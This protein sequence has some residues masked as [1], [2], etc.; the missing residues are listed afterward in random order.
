[1]QHFINLE[2]NKLLTNEFQEGRVV[3]FP[4]SSLSQVLF[5]ASNDERHFAAA[6]WE[7]ASL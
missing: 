1:M 3:S 5:Y 6:Q 4:G 2:A 7:K